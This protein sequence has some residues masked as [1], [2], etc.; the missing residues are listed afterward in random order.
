M[1]FDEGVKG[2]PFWQGVHD[3][4]EQVIPYRSMKRWS[5]FLS[6]ISGITTAMSYLSMTAKATAKMAVWLVKCWST[7]TTT[8][9]RTNVRARVLLSVLG[10]PFQFF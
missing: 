9:V 6:V 3:M 4:L 7:P 10:D 1:K 2:S 8:S 5:Q